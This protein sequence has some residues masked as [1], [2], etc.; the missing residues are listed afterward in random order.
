MQTFTHWWII[1][2]L[3]EH[4]QTAV[5]ND[6]ETLTWGTI[7]HL[8]HS[9]VAKAWKYKGLTHCTCTGYLFGIRPLAER[10]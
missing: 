6:F 2:A 8:R 7:I 1:D 9:V 10:S 3:K 5:F 4:L